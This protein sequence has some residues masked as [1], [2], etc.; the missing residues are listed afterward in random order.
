MIQFVAITPVDDSTLDL[1]DFDLVAVE[2]GKVQVNGGV[3]VIVAVKLNGG[4]KDQVKVNELLILMF[5]LT[6]WRWY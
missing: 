4:V 2:H 6:Y 1:A 5:A 3:I